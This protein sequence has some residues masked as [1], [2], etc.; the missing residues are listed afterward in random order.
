[1]GRLCKA[2]SISVFADFPRQRK[3]AIAVWTSVEHVVKEIPGQVGK[4][5]GKH[6]KHVRC[7]I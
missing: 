5:L 4:K 3:A 6:L 1:M 2:D 7:N